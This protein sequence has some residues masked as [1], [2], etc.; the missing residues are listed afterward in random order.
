MAMRFPSKQNLEL[1]LGAI[2]VDWVPVVRTDGQSG[3]RTVTWVPKFLR[4]MGYQIFLPMVSTAR[5]SRR[6]V[7]GGQFQATDNATETQN[8]TLKTYGK[9]S[10]FIFS[11]I[12]LTFWIKRCK[13]CEAFLPITWMKSSAGITCMGSHVTRG[14]TMPQTY[15]MVGLWPHF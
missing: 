12:I 4:C 10:L 14:I 2:P 11:Y 1:H 13:I 5:T 8:T 3:R 9:L 15:W 7:G 6:G